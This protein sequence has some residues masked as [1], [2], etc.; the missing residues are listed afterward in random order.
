VHFARSKQEGGRGGEGGLKFRV[1][2]HPISGLPRRGRK[3]GKRKP[4]F[5]G[6]KKKR[7]GGK[8][9]VLTLE[10][11]LGQLTIDRKEKR[12]KT[13]FNAARAELLG[14]KRKKR[15]G[16]I[17]YSAGGFTWAPVDEFPHQGRKKEKEKEEVTLP[18]DLGEGKV[19]KRKKEEVTLVLQNQA[20]NLGTAK[21]VE[22][23]RKWRGRKREK[24]KKGLEAF[25]NSRGRKEGGEEEKR[26]FLS[27]LGRN[28]SAV[29]G[30]MVGHYVPYRKGKR[31][32][33]GGPAPNCNGTAERKEGEK[34]EEEGAPLPNSK[35]CG[36]K[37]P[38]RK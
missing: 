7:G 33:G 36:L 35:A 23:A 21:I 17:G 4:M 15:E 25:S 24:R 14:G 19:K 34:K 11:R 10:S 29:G 27:L 2:P 12:E 20:M 37:Q 8:V 9:V 22:G 38:S 5:G 31:E 26:R 18:L 3:G 30:R 16:K 13:N 6:A 1:A 28:V 32:G